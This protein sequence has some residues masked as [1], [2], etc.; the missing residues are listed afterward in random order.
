MSSLR[1][2]LLEL[3]LSYTASALDDIVAR[4]QKGRWSP[5]QILEHIAQRELAERSQRSLERRLRRGK[6]G[7]FKP[8]AD[9][10]WGWPKQIDRHLV[11]SALSLDFLEHAGNVVLVAAQ[12]LGKTMI[13]KNIAH[14][15]VLAGHAVRFTTAS[16]L[17]LDLAAQ[18]SPR[19]LDRRINYWS[20]IKLLVLDEIG[21][22]S[23][24]NRNADLLFQVVSRRY[25]TK[26][27]VLTTN[28]AFKE[29][30]TIFPNAACTTAL[31]DRIVHHSTII[32]IDG[33]SYRLRDAGEAA[34]PRRR[35]ARTK[36]R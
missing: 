13:A 2:D 5:T 29:W 19:A 32:H 20:R 16:E 8:I 23:Y 11:E 30:P 4:A 17:L 15:A 34:K 7:A 26:S 10:D 25:E 31:I 1:D 22:L 14:R 6:I 28:L 12:G 18:D 3:G 27:I 33:Q 36:S 9:F 21:Y 24:D 35:K